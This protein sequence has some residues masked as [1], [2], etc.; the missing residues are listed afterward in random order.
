[1]TM[2]DVIV[3]GAGAGGA[4]VA[5]ELA[6]R[7]LSVL[8]LEGG[9]RHLK[10]A[11]EW[12][13]LDDD[14]ANP[15]T[16]RFGPRPSDLSQSPWDRE[17]AQ[18]SWAWQIAGVGGT[19]LHYFGNSPRA[20]PGAF[21]GYQGDDRDNYDTAHL[22]PFTYE[23]LRPYY[24]W[25]EATLPVHTQ[26]M[27]RK[28]EML[29][30]GA[31]R[32][33]W[34][35][36]T[37]KDTLRAGYRPQENAIIPASGTA[38]LTSDPAQLRY[39]QAQGCTSCGLCFLGCNE[40]REAPRNLAA[41]RSADNSYIPMA[42]TAG[43]W[44]RGG[45][46]ITLVADAY[47]QRILHRNVKGRATAYGVR[48]RTL[49]GRVVDVTAKIVVMS[50]GAIES[51]RLWRNSGLPNPN[52]WVGRG[53]T[54]HALD[55][56][57]GVFTTETGN[58]LG[59]SSGS[60]ADFPGYGS[61]QPIS[62]TPGLQAYGL[63]FNDTGVRG[64]YV[65]D[66]TIG[67]QGADGVGRLMGRDLR[68]MQE[69]HAYLIN[70]ACL[71]DDDVQAE[72]RVTRPRLLPPDFNGP[73]P[74]IELDGRRRTARTRRNREYLVRRAVEWLRSAG[75]TRVHRT[76]FAPLMLH[77]HSSMRMGLDPKNSVLDEY[78]KARFADGLYIADNSALANTIGGPNPTL[79]TQAVATRTAERIFQAE[80]GGD[81]WV[82]TE[83]P[84]C[85]IDPAVTA[86][87]RASSTVS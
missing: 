35:H 22:F 8:V 69:Q 83:A 85:S 26:E 38:G 7:G 6:E 41:R 72:N 71:V 55:W 12:T 30:G 14:T 3:I 2:H 78:A 29:F 76:G 63:S 54:D 52:D 46:P 68:E 60:R 65:T 17:Y 19:T 84:V 86:A 73:V 82:V 4:V 28:D 87:V 10:P 37:T 44:K 34:H 80:F 9:A 51:P 56:V 61:I 62:V 16:G 57:T 74:R 48:Y 43:T 40:P 70:L 66:P 67:P 23:Q 11:D 5:K 25:V 1:M 81:P 27:S 75:A 79:T 39:P 42:L 49:K 36:Q 64:S 18:P 77:V 59:P 32:L 15:I 58:G 13:R 20:M 45:R 24:E 50:G 21:A 53:L 33:G 31:E 47:V